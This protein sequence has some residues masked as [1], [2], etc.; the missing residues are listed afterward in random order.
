MKKFKIEDTVI[1][2]ID[3]QEGTI[4]F[5]ANR[6]H[7]VIIS[8]A[9]TLARLAKGL[10]IPVVLTS[11]QEDLQQGPLLKTYRR[12]YLFSSLNVSN[13]TVSQMPGMMKTLEMPYI[14]QLTAKKIS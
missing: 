3:H 14:R 7:E 9:R 12:F 8:R 11:S 6:A 5:S 10:N 2:L 13:A 1:L 4:N